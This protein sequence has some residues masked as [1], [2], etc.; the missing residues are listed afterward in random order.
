MLVS[1]PFLCQEENLCCCIH[2]VNICIYNSDLNVV[3][4]Q[5]SLR[6]DERKGEEEGKD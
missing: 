6:K 2:F 4:P 5:K 3:G 1:T